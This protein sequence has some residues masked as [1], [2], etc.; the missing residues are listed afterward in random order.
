[1]TVLSNEHLPREAREKCFWCGKLILGQPLFFSTADMLAPEAPIHPDCLNGKTSMQVAKRY[2]LFIAD[3]HEVAR[4]RVEY[5][6]HDD[7]GHG[8]SMRPR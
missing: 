4:K 6:L 7:Q 2:H 8:P 3:V 1:M 5:G